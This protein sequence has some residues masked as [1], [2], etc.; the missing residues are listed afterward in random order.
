[1][2]RLRGEMCISATLSFEGRELPEERMG[3]LMLHDQ[4]QQFFALISNAR[5]HPDTISEKSSQEINKMVLQEALQS[6]CKVQGRF[7]KPL[8]KLLFAHSIQSSRRCRSS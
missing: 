3:G 7:A 4:I 5:S 6:P 2:G 8:S 1:M